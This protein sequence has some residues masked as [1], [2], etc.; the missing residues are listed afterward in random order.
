MSC[1]N[2]MFFGVH[3]YI[4]HSP[5]KSVLEISTYSFYNIEFWVCYCILYGK[6]R[7]IKLF[8]W[9]YLVLAILFCWPPKY[10]NVFRSLLLL[11][12]LFFCGWKFAKRWTKKGKE[13][14]ILQPKI[15]LVD[16]RSF[17]QWNFNFKLSA[18]SLVK[19]GDRS[20]VW[21]A[22]NS[23]KTMKLID[24]WITWTDTHKIWPPNRI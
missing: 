7:V 11:N 23:T 8:I 1:V 3:E 6:L 21:G 13:I 19:S 18:Q 9:Y 14:E 16:G 5:W 20:L 17:A 22:E 4:L 10:T 24:F 12:P 15:C 2:T